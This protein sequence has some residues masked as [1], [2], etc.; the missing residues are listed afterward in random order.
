M[1]W[2]RQANGPAAFAARKA[3]ETQDGS[4]ASDLALRGGAGDENRTRTISLGSGAVTA[5]E[6]PDLLVLVVHS[7]RDC[8]LI[9]LANGT[10]MARR[11]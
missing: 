9:T 6:G 3:G 2:H 8:P 10:L 4:D 5:A 1:T 7:S 11:P